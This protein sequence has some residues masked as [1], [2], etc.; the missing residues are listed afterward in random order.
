MQKRTLIQALFL[1]AFVVAMAGCGEKDDASVA[2][3]TKQTKAMVPD[4]VTEDDLNDIPD[5]SVPA[6]DVRP[7]GHQ[8][9]PSQLP[10]NPAPETSEPAG[11]GKVTRV[12]PPAGQEEPAG[13]PPP[14]AT[15]SGPFSLQLGSFTVLAIAE[16][17]AAQLR[18]MGHAATIEQA[19]VGGQLYH[20]LFIRG[21]ADH[22]SAEKLGEELHSSLGLSYLVKRKMN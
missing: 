10:E 13:D 22:K 18:K 15:I 2:S 8:G 21:L 3:E 5:S 17:K 16:E 4:L 14:S 12:V 20:R 7:E 9:T 6:T 1:T 19:E 11:E